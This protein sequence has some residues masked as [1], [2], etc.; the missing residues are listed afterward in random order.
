MREV[1]LKDV[2]NNEWFTRKPIEEPK[3]SQVYIK[4]DYDRTDKKYCCTHWNDIGND[5]FLKG[6]TK[7]YVEFTF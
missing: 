3:E 7:V 5:V 6:S 1:L 2:K 4:G